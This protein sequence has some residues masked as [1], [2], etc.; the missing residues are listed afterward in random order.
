MT[1]AQEMGLLV[2]GFESA[3]SIDMVYTASH[4]EKLLTAEGLRRV[5]MV[6]TWKTPRLEDVKISLPG[7]G[8]ADKLDALGVCLRSMRY[9]GRNAD[10]EQIRCVVNSA[11]LGNYGFVPIT[12]AE[13]QIQLGPLLPLMDPAIVQI[14][15]VRGVMVGVSL[16]VPDFNLVLRRAKGRMLHPA[17][18][19]LFSPKPLADATVIL[20]AVRKQFQGMGLSHRLNTRLLAALRQR[21]Y[22]SLSITWIADDNTPS[23][24][25]ARALG[26]TRLHRLALF[27]TALP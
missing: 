3:P 15:E 17:M 13:W 22:R 4:Y 25:Q 19:R 10:M 9:W 5:F 21:G 26:M 18:L 27:E 14:A 8:G 1:M 16:V 11:F 20:F 7:N 2:E 24:A 23:L 12:R 6:S